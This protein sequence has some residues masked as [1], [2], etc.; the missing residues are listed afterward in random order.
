[1]EDWGAFG[2][3]RN[4]RITRSD[5]LIAAGLAVGLLLLYLATR[6]QVH[7]QGD[8]YT[9]YAALIQR[10]NLR[11][12]FDGAHLIYL[13]L[14][15]SIYQLLKTIVPGL[16]AFATAQT[17]NSLLASLAVSAFYLLAR[18]FL[19]ERWLSLSLSLVLAFSYNYWLSAT[20]VEVHAPAAV[21]YLLSLLVALRLP[22]GAPG[23]QFAAV[24]VL[25]GLAILFHA[26]CGLM[27]LV[28][29]ALVLLQRDDHVQASIR[30]DLKK[31]KSV[32]IYGLTTAF[33]VIIPY[34]FVATQ[35]LN[36]E[37]ASEI[38]SW[39]LEFRETP[40]FYD[41]A[42]LP[43]RSTLRLAP[44]GIGRAFLGL[45]VWLATPALGEMLL[46][47]LPDKCFGEEL[48]L[49]RDL[50][51]ALALVL[52]TSSCVAGGL[53]ASLAVL[54]VPGL[55]TVLKRFSRVAIGLMVWLIL[56]AVLLMY[57]GPGSYE[58]WAIYWLPI[59]FLAVG[60][61][62]GQTTP[63]KGDHSKLVQGLAVALVT[64]LFVA[65]LGNILLQT[66]ADNDI[67]RHRLSWYQ[68][69]AGAKDLI[70]SAGGHKWWGYTAY[71]LQARVENLDE[72]FR[73]M[74]YPGVWQDIQAQIQLTR[75]SGGRVFVMQD[76]LEPELC[77]APVAGWDLALY[78]S[79]RHDIMPR[80]DCFPSDDISICEVVR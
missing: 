36:L 14:Q 62:L 65:N 28:V 3:I 56:Y 69:N 4:H 31:L 2:S 42:A 20:D 51:P 68:T 57:S 6:L 79:F 29:I 39:I 53:L 60:L 58:A 59:F 45:I 78:A 46:Q 47:A 8:D 11:D 34:L 44:I 40:G 37:T 55:V 21:F 19:R 75:A 77:Y 73:R 1:M 5:R 72:R 50:A 27:S 7:N 22:A 66:R 38:L 64:S 76:A 35:V 13:W 15:S 41:R 9:N 12:L 26:F 48:Y 25:T 74:D 23:W 49:V 16:D 43:L 10:G 52:T 61:G 30:V 24:G 71:Y 33:C 32:L 17:F 18:G 70:I 80:L 63:Q 54:S 67:Y